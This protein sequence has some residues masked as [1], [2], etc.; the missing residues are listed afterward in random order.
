MNFE[1]AVNTSQSDAQLLFFTGTTVIE[2]CRWEKMGS[3]SEIITG[4]F[5]ETIN[6]HNLSIDDLKKINCVIG[7]GSFTGVRVA[8]NFCKTLAYSREI[9]VSGIN[10]LSL[11]A[12]QC[13]T[14]L[15]KIYS[16]I[17]AQKNSV[18]FSS[19]N[20]DGHKVEIDKENLVIPVDKLSEWMEIPGAICGNAHPK[21]KEVS[22]IKDQFNHQLDSSWFKMDLKV[23]LNNQNFLKSYT[24]FG[25]AGVLEA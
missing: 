19:F 25:L 5:Q 10:S 22:Q 1:I 9:E 23:I 13:D 11:F 4:K 14:A 3:H 21:Y 17:D 20:F 12:L 6:K 8:I 24:G 2:D 16:L 15:T 18:F 7:P